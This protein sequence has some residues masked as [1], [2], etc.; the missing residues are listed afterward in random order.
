MCEIKNL[1]EKL[2]IKNTDDCI[3]VTIRGLFALVISIN[4]NMK[5]S[6]F[7]SF[8]LSHGVVFPL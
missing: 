6:S 7:F 3:V 4:F 8:F 2:L 1:R 5:L